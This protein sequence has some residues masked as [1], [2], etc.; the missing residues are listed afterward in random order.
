MSF[1]DRNSRASASLNGYL[2]PFY[3]RNTNFKIPDGKATFSSGVTARNSF[4]LNVPEHQNCVWV[5]LVPGFKAAYTIHNVPNTFFNPFWL[6]NNHNIRGLLGNSTD[7]APNQHSFDLSSAES[8]CEKIRLVSAGMKIFCPNAETANDG[9]FEA[10]RVGSANPN[11]AI[12]RNAMIDD[13]TYFTGKISD[14]SKYFFQ[15]KPMGGHDFHSIIYDSQTIL[16][17]ADNLQGT[18]I[19]V[20]VVSRTQD[21][22]V[23]YTSDTWGN[24]VTPTFASV[25]DKNFDTVVI[26]LRTGQATDLVISTTHNFEVIFHP[27]SSASHFHTSCVRDK[28][29]L[30]Q[31]RAALT[32]NIKAGDWSYHRKKL[33]ELGVT[34]GKRGPRHYNY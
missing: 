16:N 3:T 23:T 32:K 4:A 6:L 14:L 33:D 17:N 28:L 24:L 2:N 34:P 25:L 20:G 30:G 18:D 29:A 7:D 27:D 12:N 31:A 21:D 13:P 26:C 8:R 5:A 11:I 9:W 10:I 15:C 22:P 19:D 1:T